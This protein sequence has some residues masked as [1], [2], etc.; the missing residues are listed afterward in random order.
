MITL[1]K[2]FN[3]NYRYFSSV[4]YITPFRKIQNIFIFCITITLQN[5][6]NIKHYISNF[7][8]QVET[9]DETNCGVIPEN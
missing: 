1:M 4:T 6:L 7:I 8:L 3:S 5:T 9:Y 2:A